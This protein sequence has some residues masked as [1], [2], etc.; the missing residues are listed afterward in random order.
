MRS[1]HT[2]D[3]TQCSISRVCS[4]WK[5]LYKPFGGQGFALEDEEG[6]YGIRCI[7]APIFDHQGL[8]E[9]AISITALLIN[10]PVH[11]ITNVGEK[12]KRTALDIS[13][14]LGYKLQHEQAVSAV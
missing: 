8:L 12:V 9:A 5:P 4:S 3:D 1:S 14:R 2:V 10:L 7:G 6:E 13:R 11:E